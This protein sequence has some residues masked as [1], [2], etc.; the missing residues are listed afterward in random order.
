MEIRS[1]QQKKGVFPQKISEL[2]QVKLAQNNFK[3]IFTRPS[4]W[5]SSKQIII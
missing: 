4:R 2:E 5:E 3:K 1:Y